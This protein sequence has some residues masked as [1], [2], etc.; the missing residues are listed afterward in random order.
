MLCIASF[1]TTG[2]PVWP[3]YARAPGCRTWLRWYR[4][5]EDCGSGR[6]PLASRTVRQGARSSQRVRCVWRGRE[7]RRGDSFL[8]DC[9]ARPDADPKRRLRR[10][11]LQERIERMAYLRE[12]PLRIEV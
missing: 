4:V 1:A 5:P 2:L 7:R 3:G 11:A 6:S 12:G 8:G 10:T 9:C